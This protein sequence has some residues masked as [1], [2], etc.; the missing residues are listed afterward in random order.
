M[1]GSHKDFEFLPDI[2]WSFEIW[3]EGA[4]FAQNTQI[5]TFDIPESEEVRAH[6]QVTFF[7]TED[8]VYTGRI[9][10]RLSPDEE[11]TWR[12]TSVAISE[13]DKNH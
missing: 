12:V 2:V 3:E 7:G 8:E 1:V 11:I 10:F 5:V 4:Y 13:F 6:V 9:L